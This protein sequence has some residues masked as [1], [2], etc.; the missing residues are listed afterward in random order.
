MLAARGGVALP[1][2]VAL[3]YLVQ[4]ALA[5]LYCHKRK[6]LHRDLKLAN[7][8]VA[9]DSE[10]RLGDFGA[11]EGRGRDAGMSVRLPRP[12]PRPPTPTHTPPQASLE[13]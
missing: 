3:D 8:F 10:L 11:Q 1:E 2:G 7:I 13:F 12:A 5:L 4:M 9:G 6:V